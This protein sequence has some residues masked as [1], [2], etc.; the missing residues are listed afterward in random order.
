MNQESLGKRIQRLRKAKGLTQ[1]Q[2]AGRLGVSPQAVSKW[3]N[4]NCS[5][6]ISLLAALAQELGVSTDALLRGEGEEA[7]EPEVM[8]STEKDGF[9]FE[10][11]SKE[12]SRET[13]FF[14]NFPV[15]A[16]EIF[17]ALFVI[18]TGVLLIIHH[19]VA[20]FACGFWSL[21]WPIAIIMLVGLPSVCKRHPS[22]FGIGMTLLGTYALLSN[23]EV[24]PFRLEWWVILAAALVLC[25]VSALLSAFRRPRRKM[26]KHSGHGDKVA[27]RSF[28]EDNGMIHMECRFCD[29]NSAMRPQELRGGEASVSFGDAE[30]DL[31]AL[32]GVEDGAALACN[33]SFGDLTIILPRSV[34]VVQDG[35]SSFGDISVKGCPDAGAEEILGINASVSFGELTI[36]YR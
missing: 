18:L 23:L 26:C 4:D 13:S 35:G 1:E 30:L 32:T 17:G 29:L 8:D 15:K 9:S 28:T 16:S 6:D 12:D 36:Q 5:P 19:T 31:T 33:V 27:F 14:Q 10:Y 24:I 20:P 22:L 21:I 34:R 25:G 7:F 2:L 11:H 3:E